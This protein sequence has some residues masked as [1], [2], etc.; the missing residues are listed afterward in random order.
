MVRCPWWR[1]RRA[2]TL[3]AFGAR[4]LTLLAG[5]VV[6]LSF[7]G[8]A[9]DPQRPWWYVASLAIMGLLI[10]AGAQWR[11]RGHDLF[12]A[13][14]DHALA[15]CR[16]MVERKIGVPWE[17]RARLDHLDEELVTWMGRAGCT[18]VLLGVESGDADLRTR[19][20]KRMDPGLDP[21]E[22]TARLADAGIVPILS[23]ILG[24]PGESEAELARTI[25]SDFRNLSL[26][27]APMRLGVDGKNMAEQFAY[28]RDM[29]LL[30][31]DYESEARFLERAR[32]ALADIDDFKSLNDHFGHDLGD[33]VLKEVA[34]AIESTVRPQDLVARWGG[35]E[36][37]LFFAEVG[38]DD[39]ELIAERVRQAVAE[40]SL[41]SEL[42]ARRVSITVGIAERLADESL[43]RSIDRADQGLYSGKQAGKNR[44]VR[45]ACACRES[46]SSSVSPSAPGREYVS[47]SAEASNAQT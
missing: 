2:E 19:H 30:E 41:P 31:V 37:I 8:F 6:F 3:G 36:F 17:C 39:A 47:V 15:F 1:D 5:L 10:A 18:R 28:V 45:A 4:W 25:E 21:L 40:V 23:L 14:R 12:G 11:R 9:Q 27:T 34:A 29:L 20:G 46:R 44:V 42:G 38:V 7:R 16:A 35:E 33:L 43:D 24:L 22:V 13:A 32:A 26:L